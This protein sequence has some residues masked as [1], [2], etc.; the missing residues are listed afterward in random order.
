MHFA[1]T[2]IFQKTKTNEMQSCGVQPQ[3]IHLQKTPTTKA[4]ET[5]GK[6]GINM[7]RARGPELCC[8]IVS[9]HN[10]RSYSNKTLTKI[11][12][13]SQVSVNHD[14]ITGEKAMTPASS[15]P[16]IALMLKLYQETKFWSSREGNLRK[17]AEGVK[18]HISH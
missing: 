12:E 16:Q 2:H 9:L 1:F 15:M 13:E 6:G 8:E 7:V 4:Q 18:I 3:W 11:R 5:F 10:T 17:R 14:P